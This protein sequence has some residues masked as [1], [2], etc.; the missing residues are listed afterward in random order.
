[1]P[2]H[3]LAIAMVLLVVATA[4]SS[5]SSSGNT[6]TSTTK[7]RPVPAGICRADAAPPSEYESVIVFAF[8]NRTWSDVG[9]GFGPEMPYLHQLGEQCAFFRK[10]G[11]TDPKQT[12]LAQY[13]GQITGTRQPGTVND[14]NPSA[15]CSTRAD[16]L[17][18]QVW[19][20]GGRAVNYVVGATAPCS[21]DHNAPRHVPALYLWD[22]TDKRHC[23][24]QVRPLAE[25]DVNDLPNFAFVTPNECN[26]GHDCGNRVVD[27][28][29]R[30]HVQ[31]VLDSD[32]YKAGKVAVFIWYDED[33]PVPNLWNTPTASTGPLDTEGAGS[34]AT[35]R[36]WQSMLG[37]PCL[38][39]ACTATDLR[40]AANS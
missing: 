37:L 10:W 40:P 11:E 21:A 12:S 4:C 1:V 15:K 33:R 38:A 32:A 6:P 36:A 20:S 31:P 29:A 23:K 13:V 5:G 9:L 3:Q 24:E 16:N 22:R 27:G 17:F 2:K 18:R 30:D 28:W 14:C 7:T 25:L 19:S 8:E 39:N 34:P 26:D 35:L